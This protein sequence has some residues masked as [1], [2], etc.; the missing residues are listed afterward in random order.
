MERDGSAHGRQPLVWAGTQGGIVGVSSARPGAGLRESGG[1]LL[2]QDNLGFH[3]PRPGSS[4]LPLCGVV[5]VDPE[6]DPGR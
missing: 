3:P 4:A 1:S 6:M 5:Q 2:S